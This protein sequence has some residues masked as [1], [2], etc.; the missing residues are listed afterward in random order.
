MSALASLLDSLPLACQIEV[1]NDAGVFRLVKVRPDGW[2]DPHDGITLHT[3]DLLDGEPTSVVL[4]DLYGEDPCAETEVALTP[5][6]PDA[7]R[8]I[9]AEGRTWTVVAEVATSG[10]QDPPW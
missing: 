8:T 4:V 6:A 5:L 1:T 3:L 10:A 2:V 9:A 7:P